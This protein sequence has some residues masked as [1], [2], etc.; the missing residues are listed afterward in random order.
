M[1]KYLTNGANPNKL[2]I[3]IPSYGR[4]FEL[5]S[6]NKTRPGSPTVG[7]G[8]PGSIT[9]ETGVLGYFEVIFFNKFKLSVKIL[10][11]K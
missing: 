9:N 8:K 4:S 11:T 3:G 6:I 10:F 5:E 2:V 7:S 1:A